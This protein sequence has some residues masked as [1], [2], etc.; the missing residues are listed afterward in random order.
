M[1]NPLGIQITAHLVM[2]PTGSGKSN[3]KN[4]LFSSDFTRLIDFFFQFIDRLTKATKWSGD[5]LKPFTKDVRAIRIQLSNR[6]VVLVDTPAFDN[7][8]RSDA[9]V[10]KLIG[11][12]L[13]KM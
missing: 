3:V 1:T 12:W 7:P 13:K 5:G 11:E 4:A 8:D 10:L 9:T 2:G 6:N